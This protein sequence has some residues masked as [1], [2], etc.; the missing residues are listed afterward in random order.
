M[1][2][3]QEELERIIRRLSAKQ[4]KL[5]LDYARELEEG[6]TPEEVADIEAGKAEV[7]RGEWIDWDDLKREL[8]L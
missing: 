8:N 7:A 4:L 6:L 3:I 2:V 1:S 5:L